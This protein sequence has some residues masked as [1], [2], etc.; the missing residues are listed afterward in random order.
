MAQTAR[1]AR[2]QN[3]R[4]RALVQNSMSAETNT[5]SQCPE[6][7]DIQL[8]GSDRGS[9]GRA[10][11]FDGA[12]CKYRVCRADAQ[13]GSAPEGDSTAGVNIEGRN[14]RQR[15]WR[16]LGQ[17][18][19]ALLPAAHRPCWASVALRRTATGLHRPGFCG[20][21]ASWKTPLEPQ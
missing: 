2:R 20:K 6:L 1:E 10:Q 7:A 12:A 11:T 4:R 5:L 19:L 21:M 13:G 15:G 17:P 8:G 16:R 18:R 3:H 14:A 9:H